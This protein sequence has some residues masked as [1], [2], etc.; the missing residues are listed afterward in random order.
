MGKGIGGLS[1][2]PAIDHHTSTSVQNRQVRV[3]M[4]KENSSKKRSIHRILAWRL[5]L[6][7]LLISVALG[8]IVFFSERDRIGETVIDNA[9]QG[10]VNFNYEVRALLDEPGLPDRDGIQRNLEAFTSRG[11]RQMIGHF[12]F[13]NIYDKTSTE[14]AKVVDGDHKHIAAVEAFINTSRTPSDLPEY[15]MF[16]EVRK[17]DG[18]PHI[19]VAVPLTNS[20][21]KVVAQVNGVFAVSPKAIKEIE[22]RVTRTVLAVVAIVLI[23]TALLYPIITRLMQ[24]V[25]NLS[26]NLLDSHLE[27]LKVLGSAIAKR[28]SDTDAHNFRVTILSVRLAEAVGLSPQSIRGLI[29]GAF[30][31]DVGKIGISDNI[32]LKPGRLT[33]KEFEVMKG[34]VR[35]GLDIVERSV[36]LRD[37]TDVVGHHHEKYDGRGYGEGLGSEEIPVGARIFAIA[38]VFDALTSRRPY[39]EPLTFD[40]AMSILEEG[41]GSHFD[42]EL[43][44]DFVRIAEPLYDALYNHDVDRSR[45]ELE[46][47]LKEY[48]EGDIGSFL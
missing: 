4:K 44:G 20:V 23:T 38:D 1:C 9:F 36:W 22:R 43:L 45:Q 17:I 26:L 24:R 25:T 10:A 12:V 8:S 28:D 46:S 15:D 18:A 16:H 19:R 40:E 2:S 27:T 41:R 7:A 33:D 31:H 3:E 35:H 21:G 14:I 6:P 32:L 5:S 47:I 42:P 29:K 34:H 13:I 39:K 30:L 48:F 11:V 37:A